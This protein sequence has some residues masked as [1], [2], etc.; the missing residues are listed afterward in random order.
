[1]SIK[2][3]VVCALAAF[4]LI[5]AAVTSGHSSDA[6]RTVRVGILSK[7]LRLLREGEIA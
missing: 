4:F 2:K 5:A 1:M 3:T 7:P 6:G